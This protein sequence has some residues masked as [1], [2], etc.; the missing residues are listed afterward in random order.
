MKCVQS[1]KVNTN[2]LTKLLDSAAD[3]HEFVSAVYRSA[4]LTTRTSVRWKN[5]LPVAMVF[6]GSEFGEKF[7]DI[8]L[9]HPNAREYLSCVEEFR[10][11]ATQISKEKALLLRALNANAI[12]S[13]MSS[14]DWIGRDSDAPDPVS[15]DVNM[16][17]CLG[18]KTPRDGTVC[19][20]SISV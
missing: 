17:I 14:K 13:W 3:A 9:Q 1:H 18:S 15:F 7:I 5:G 4:S 20:E 11:V 16:G 10:L 12:V 6:F 8:L 2:Q 19:P